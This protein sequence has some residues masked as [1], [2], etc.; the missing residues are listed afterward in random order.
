M[1]R[2]TENAP[3]RRLAAVLLA[4][5]ASALVVCASAHGAADTLAP[6]TTI[7]AATPAANGVSLDG[8]ASFSFVSSEADSS[9]ECR[10]DAGAVADSWRPCPSS[11]QT[12]AS[13]GDGGVFIFRVRAIDGAG[14]VDGSPAV[15][16]FRVDLTGPQTTIGSGPEELSDSTTAEFRY[17]GSEADNV[18]ECSLDGGAWQRCD[19]ERVI[20]TGLADGPHSFAVRALDIAGRVDPSPAAA[21]WTI[22]TSPEPPVGPG[23]GV[24]TLELILSRAPTPRTTR[25]RARFA[26]A[27]SPTATV[28]LLCS[29]DRGAFSDC[30]NGR[31]STRVSAGRHRL[32]VRIDTGSL[33]APFAAER[34]RYRWRVLA[35]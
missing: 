16:S 3:L 14:N 5:A 11:G 26:F 19:G 2:Q 20:Y 23:P 17:F 12:Y 21:S 8:R 1:D 9:F 34:L 13:L 27:V 28:G 32:E 10:L 18:F 6:Q 25:A 22:D 30:S 7:A 31:Y 29:L 24:S 4:C 35:R 33:D 15:S